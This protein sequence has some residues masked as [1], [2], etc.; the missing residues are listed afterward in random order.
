MQD[1]HLKKVQKKNGTLIIKIGPI[2][3]SHADWIYSVNSRIRKYHVQI[4]VQYFSWDK[5]KSCL[6]DLDLEVYI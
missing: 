5:T 4:S 3:L 1:K 6:M 2:L